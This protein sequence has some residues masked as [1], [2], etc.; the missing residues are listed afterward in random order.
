MYLALA[1][2]DLRV[3]IILIYDS[4]QIDS[5]YKEPVTRKAYP[6][7]GDI[8]KGCHRKFPSATN[9]EGVSYI[10]RLIAKTIKVPHDVANGETIVIIAV[11]S[12][13]STYD[14]CEDMARERPYTTMAR[15]SDVLC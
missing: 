10:S 14:A 2:F 6:Y 8:I 5:H 13:I 7:D 12:R 1:E 4:W 3:H 15:G 11:M 9:E